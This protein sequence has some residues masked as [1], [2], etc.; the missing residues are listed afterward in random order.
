LKVFYGVLPLIL[1]ITR[2]KS[3]NISFGKEDQHLKLINNKNKFTYDLM[4]L[5]KLGKDKGMALH[6]EA[7]V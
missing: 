4:P 1:S 5:H 6:K 3:Q 2:F 7:R